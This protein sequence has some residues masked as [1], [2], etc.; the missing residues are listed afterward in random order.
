MHPRENAQSSGE[1]ELATLCVRAIAQIVHGPSLLGELELYASIRSH[2]PFTMGAVLT[3][4]D[5]GDAI[6]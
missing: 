3:H 6:R 2:I 1:E 5:D 4:P